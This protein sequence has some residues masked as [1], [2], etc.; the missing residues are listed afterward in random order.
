MR[1][2]RKKPKQGD[3]RATCSTCGVQFFASAGG[4]ESILIQTLEHWRDAHPKLF[5]EQREK[6]RL[7]DPRFAAIYDRVAAG[8]TN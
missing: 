5:A 6:A 2:L 3:L 7:R 1:D 4:E 8:N